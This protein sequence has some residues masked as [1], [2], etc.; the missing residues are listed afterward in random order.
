M[1]DH[2]GRAV[3]GARRQRDLAGLQQ[4]AELEVAAPVGKDLGEDV[5]V[6]APRQMRTPDLPCPL[7]EGSRAGEHQGDVLVRR[8]AGA[9]L[10]DERPTFERRPV[11]VQLAGPTPRELQQLTGL[12]RERK[13]DV[14]PLQLIRVGC[15]RVRDRDA[16]GQ[17]IGERHRRLEDEH[18]DVIDGD[19]YQDSVGTGVRSVGEA[20]RPRSTARSMTCQARATRETGTVLGNDR[21]RRLDVKTSVSQRP[22]R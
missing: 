6:A 4:F 11:R 2:L 8:A 10:G 18:G 12:R 20:R 19:S 16:D 21:Q 7:A 9:V 15:A 17:G 5:V 3:A 22:A 13:G 14:E 1:R